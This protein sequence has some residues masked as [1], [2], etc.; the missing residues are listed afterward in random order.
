MQLQQFDYTLPPENIAQ[1]PVTPRDHSR[2]LYL[3]RQDHSRQ[4][5]HFYDLPTLLKPGDVL[6]I[7]DT[8]VI[9]VRLLGHKNTGGKIE[10]LLTKKIE[11]VSNQLQ[12]WEALTHPGM[13]TGQKAVFSNNQTRLEIE[14]LQDEGYVKTVQVTTPDN[15]ILEALTDLGTLPTP[16][17][18]KK[19][20]GDP[21]RYQTVFANKNG[22]AAAPTAGLHF[23]PELM[24]K[25][26]NLGVQV[27]PVT[28]HVGYGTFSPVR[29]KDITKH[30]MH[31]EWFEVSAEAASSINQAKQA[32]HRVVAVGTTS[33]RTLESAAQPASSTSFSSSKNEQEKYTKNAKV[34][35][36]SRETDLFV[37]PPHQFQ[38]VDA[39][40]TNFHLPE[41]TLLMLVSAFATYPQTEE[42]FTDFATSWLGQSYQEAI[43][44]NYRL[45]SFGDAMFIE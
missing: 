13:K 27:V 9:P 39:L 30:Q 5:L 4:H 44:K 38:I 15:S 8:K 25:I 21:Q 24:E 40:I 16:P 29:E 26:K 14:C 43:E 31:S 33:L 1:Q 41:S 7:N 17:Y 28:L 18:I 6:V 19:F 3:R 36:Q 32:G 10:V 22:S 12:T 34:M 37:Y 11:H 45:F 35:A 20:V 23:T 2:L 42:K